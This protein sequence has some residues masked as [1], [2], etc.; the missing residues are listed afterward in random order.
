M[1]AA[2][3]YPSK[4]F[5]SQNSLDPEAMVGHEIRRL[6]WAM[7]SIYAEPGYNVQDLDRTV[8]RIAGATAWTAGFVRGAIF[9]HAQLQHLPRLRELQRETHMLDLPHLIAV[10]KALEEL[11]PDVA[12]EVY[13]EF[14]A[15]LIRLFTPSRHNMRL[16]GA[17]TVRKHIRDLIKRMDPARGYDEE[18][19]GQRSVNTD[20]QLKCDT[21]TLGGVEKSR[22]ELLTNATKSKQA[23]LHIAATARAHGITMIDAALK[24][25]SGEIEGGTTVTLHVYSP[26]DRAEGEPVYIPGSGWTDPAATA[27]FDDLLANITPDVSDL[28]VAMEHQVDGYV[29]TPKMRS[30]VIARDGTCI[31]PGCNVPADHCQLDHR[32]PYQDGGPTTPANLFALCQHH[33]NFKTDRRAFYFPDPHTGDILWC[34]DDGTYELVEPG[35]LIFDQITSTTPRWRTSLTNARRNRARIAEFNAKGHT[36]LDEFDEDQDLFKAVARILEV[37]EEYGLHFQFS[38]KPRWVEP[39]PEEP[40][41][42]EPPFPDPEHYN[43][44]PNPFHEK[45]F[46]PASFVEWSLARAQCAHIMSTVQEAA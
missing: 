6:Y 41:F 35:G 16:P 1:T 17:R 5:R 3:T 36:I 13:D 33:H 2:T 9:A 19:R 27:E 45:S 44:D 46:K 28:D 11:G 34:F 24:L 30:A 32:I 38:A 15:M 40:D 20:D 39:L 23:Q 25:L 42:E 8:D 7:F 22:I 26:K 10:N 12:E 29:P 37:E 43:P 14:D 21:K 18:K 31:Y 4:Q